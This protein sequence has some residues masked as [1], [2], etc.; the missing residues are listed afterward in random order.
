MPL[1]SLK[2]PATTANLGSGFDT[3]GMALSLYNIFT[4]D[5]ILPE[6]EYTCE[7]SGEGVDEKNGIY[8]R[9]VLRFRAVML[10]L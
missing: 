10:C 5:K 1:I 2:V 4:V 7:I 3:L 9:K 6:G 8:R